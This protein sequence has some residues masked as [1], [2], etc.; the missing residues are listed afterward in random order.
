MRD[1]ICCHRSR[2]ALICVT[3]PLAAG[4]TGRLQTTAAHA[5][6]TVAL[7]IAADDIQPEQLAVYTYP[8]LMPARLLRRYK[9][10]LGDVAFAGAELAAADFTTIHV[11]NTGPMTGLLDTLPAEALLSVSSDPKRKYAHTLEFLRDSQVP[12]T[13]TSH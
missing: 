3:P 4:A 11:P 10:F 9:R 7:A 6:P 13:C 12:L 2:P 8:Q 5:Q 1:S